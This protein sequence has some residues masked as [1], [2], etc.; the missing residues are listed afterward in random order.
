[1][2]PFA[3]VDS[4]QGAGP[5]TGFFQRKIRTSNGDIITTD[6]GLSMVVPTP[7]GTLGAHP[8]RFGGPR[9]SRSSA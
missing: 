2:T 8:Q 4:Q 1:M 6:R 5:G 9:K 3:S 7:F